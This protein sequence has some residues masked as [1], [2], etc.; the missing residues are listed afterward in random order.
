VDGAACCGPIVSK[1]DYILPA[2]YAAFVCVFSLQRFNFR[3]RR[4]VSIIASTEERDVA[5]VV[6]Y[7]QSEI[8]RQ[9]KTR[10]PCPI[11]DDFAQTLA[12]AADQYIVSAGTRRRSLA[13]ITVS[14]TGAAIR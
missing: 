9:R 3:I 12:A 7:R 11:E 6:E 8:T 10:V 5:K 2:S 13:D 4:Q 14:A 1:T